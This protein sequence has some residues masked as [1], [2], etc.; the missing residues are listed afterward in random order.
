MDFK[1][2]YEFLNSFRITLVSTYICGIA[3]CL[4]VCYCFHFTVFGSFLMLLTIFILNTLFQTICAK[5]QFHATV[6]RQLQRNGLHLELHSSIELVIG[7]ASC[8]AWENCTLL[9]AEYLSSSFYIKKNELSKYPIFGCTVDEFNIESPQQKSQDGVVYLYSPLNVNLNLVHANIKLPF[10][11]RYHSPR[12]GGG[13]IITT[14][15]R[16]RLLLQC[17][18]QLDS[19]QNR[20]VS[21]PCPV[22]SDHNCSWTDVPYKT[23][24]ES[25]SVPVPVGDTNHIALISWVTYVLAFGGSAFLAIAIISATL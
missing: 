19:S 15:H 13:H 25:L 6:L 17:N 7:S 24:A 8:P 10:H 23:N 2:K 22:C 3:T 12:S 14:L 18:E 9:V 20:K 21:A 1:I 11:L 4:L 5:C 16:P